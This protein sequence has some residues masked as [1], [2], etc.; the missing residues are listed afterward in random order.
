MVEGEND[1][2]KKVRTIEEKVGESETDLR[3]DDG[4]VV[5]EENGTCSHV[6]SVEY[7]S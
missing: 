7:R 2:D 5:R 6:V 4:L 3:Y 1:E